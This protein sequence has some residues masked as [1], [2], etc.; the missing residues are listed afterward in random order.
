MPTAKA[1]DIPVPAVQVGRPFKYQMPTAEGAA[2]LEITV[3][4]LKTRPRASSD[5]KG[6][7]TLCVSFKLRNVG[8]VKYSSDDTDAQTGSQW[9]GLDGRQA[10]TTPGTIGTC[11]GLGQEWAGIEQPAPSPG[12]YVSGVWMYNIPGGPGALEVTDSAGSPL[13]RID[14]GPKSSQVHISAVGQ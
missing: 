8:T 3:T 14:Y 7:V 5:P 12:K 9:F 11:H 1:S 2:H 6:T 10:D 13:Y 4:G